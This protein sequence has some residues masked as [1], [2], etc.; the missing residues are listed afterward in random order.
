MKCFFFL[1]FLYTSN[2]KIQIFYSLL[3]CFHRQDR[4][5]EDAPTVNNVGGSFQHV[6]GHYDPITHQIVYT[7]QQ[8][9]K[10]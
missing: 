4:F 9:S 5:S 3:I 7:H 10:Y 6:S 2:G 1:L 8:S